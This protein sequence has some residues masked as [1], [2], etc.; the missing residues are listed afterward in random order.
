MMLDVDLV[1]FLWVY[2]TTPSKISTERHASNLLVGPQNSLC[3][4]KIGFIINHIVN[5]STAI[6]NHLTFTLFM[7]TMM[8]ISIIIVVVAII[9][10]ILRILG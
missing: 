5:H 4:N 1:V 6:I 10:I 7:L 8:M 9:T 3:A 2:G